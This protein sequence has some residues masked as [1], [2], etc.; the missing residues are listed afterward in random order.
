MPRGAQRFVSVSQIPPLFVPMQH[1]LKTINLHFFFPE[2]N[3]VP[4]IAPVFTCS[5]SWLVRRYIPLLFVCFHRTILDSVESPSA[6]FV[7]S[8]KIAQN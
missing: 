6:F 5:S 7:K 2:H 3:N 1:M 4:L 8:S